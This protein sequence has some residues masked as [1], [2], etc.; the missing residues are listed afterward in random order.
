[1][2]NYFFVIPTIAVQRSPNMVRVAI[3]WG[4]W[5]KSKFFRIRRK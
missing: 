2:T 3:Y 5:S 1:M 4:F